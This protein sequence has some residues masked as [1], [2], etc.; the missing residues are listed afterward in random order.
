M[1]TL[2]CCAGRRLRHLGFQSAEL[3]KLSPQLEASACSQERL[4]N[5]SDWCVFLHH[6]H[7]IPRQTRIL[8]RVSS[9]DWLC[10][11]KMTLPSALRH[12]HWAWERNLSPF[13]YYTKKKKTSVCSIQQCAEDCHQVLAF[14]KLLKSTDVKWNGRILSC[15]DLVPEIVTWPFQYLPIS[16]ILFFQVNVTPSVPLSMQVKGWI[17]VNHG[18]T[19]HTHT[20]MSG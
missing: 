9:L 10:G 3:E 11:L 19:M 18:M 8:Q 20:K 12:C 17:S 7:T 15:C 2:C 5:T 13:L 4:G 14:K 6:H 16:L 1:S